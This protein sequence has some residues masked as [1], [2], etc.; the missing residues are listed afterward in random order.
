MPAPP[1]STDLTLDAIRRHL[2]TRTVGQTLE[3]LDE[4]SSTNTVALTLAHAGA[5]DGTV[6]LAD[7][8][9][10]GRGRLGRAWHSPRGSNLYC[11]IVLR[12]DIEPEH[13]ANWLSWVPLTAGMA[14]A[15][16]M[17]CISD[18]RPMLKWPNDILMGSRKVGGVL[19]EGAGLQKRHPCVVVGIG[20]NVNVEA[21]SFPDEFREHATSLAAEAGRQF[22]RAE[23]LA[24]LLRELETVW[25]ELSAQSG[26]ERV[27]G[28]S[29]VCATLG[30]TVE[31]QL[32]GNASVRGR[33]IA[34]GLDGSLHV[35][36]DATGEGAGHIEPVIVRA[37]DVV[38]VR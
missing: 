13:L 24:T 22:N 17:T 10:A 35:R 9:T 21:N 25:E 34:I 3:L 20:M 1:L 14:A 23:L 29:R 18:L 19:C 37:G 33:A 15:R 28:Y 8:Q 11:S 26:A 12:R 2:R 38:H 36:Q 32:L 27:R 16:A 5:S 30:R 7:H 6:V 4:T 31:V